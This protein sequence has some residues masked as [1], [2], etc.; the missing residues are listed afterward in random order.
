MDQVRGHLN[1]INEQALQ[2]YEA[3]EEEKRTAE[4]GAYQ[5]MLELTDMLNTNFNTE[6]SL[7]VYVK[8]LY[9]LYRTE[10]DEYAKKHIKPVHKFSATR[11]RI[12]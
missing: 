5:D 11:N 2:E 9:S 6:Q 12:G 4:D 1:E 7:Y 8:K 3:Q 10:G